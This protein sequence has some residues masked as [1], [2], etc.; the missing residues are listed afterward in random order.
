VGDYWTSHASFGCTKD[1]DHP[2]VE[3]HRFDMGK[4]V[5]RCGKYCIGA[6]VM[7]QQGWRMFARHKPKE[8]I[9]FSA[10]DFEG[11]PESLEE[12]EKLF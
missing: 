6:P 9:Q 2:G 10:P 3:I 12:L 1:I 11:I 7:K 4:R 8:K 5:C